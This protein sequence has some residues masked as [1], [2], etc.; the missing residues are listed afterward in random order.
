MSTHEIIL[1]DKKEQST[2]REDM[3]GFNKY[4]S[5]WKKADTQK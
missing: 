3:G 1:H 2:D 4:V 5:E